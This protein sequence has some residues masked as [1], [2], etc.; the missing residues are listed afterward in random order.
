MT[1]SNHG[2][3]G[4]RILV[5]EDEV[6]VGILLE[7]L[8]EDAGGRV[9]LAHNVEGARS[10]IRQETF[11]GALLDINLHGRTTEDVADDLVS[12]SIPFIVITG[13]DS[14]DTDPRT[15]KAAPRLLKP[16]TRVELLRRMTEV[17]AS[18]TAV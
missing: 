1:T 14:R 13:Y 11:D 5:V 15:I 4:L 9:K 12:R 3:S 6:T 10:M 8:L 2:L 18:V 17:F 16:F 7:E